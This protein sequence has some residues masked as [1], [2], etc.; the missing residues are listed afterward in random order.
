M[1][2]RLLISK[3]GSHVSDEAK[4]IDDQ[5]C[6]FINPSSFKLSD[7]KLADKIFEEMN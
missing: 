1:L 2:N 3:E 7:K 6:Y 5:I 4:Y